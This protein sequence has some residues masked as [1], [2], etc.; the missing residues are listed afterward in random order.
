MTGETRA[1]LSQYSGN[2]VVVNFWA[3]WCGPCRT[4]TPMLASAARDLSSQGVRFL[5]V[6]IRD[7]KAA[8]AAF[9]REFNVGFP[10]IYDREASI[11]AAWGVAAPP[12]TFVVTAD[13]QV[14]AAHPGPVE[15]T[16]L[17]CMVEYARAGG[18]VE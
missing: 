12:A 8:A 2:V 10:S 16:D 14:V 1:A 15:K 18:D 13:G 9:E 7:D 5:G 17:T 4:E 11:A 3:S 6:N